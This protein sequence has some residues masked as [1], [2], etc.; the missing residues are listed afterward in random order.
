MYGL[1]LSLWYFWYIDL[2]IWQKF[3]YVIFQS[4]LTDF[5]N[6]IIDGVENYANL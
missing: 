3:D 1:E 2:I 4:I 6:E 5:G